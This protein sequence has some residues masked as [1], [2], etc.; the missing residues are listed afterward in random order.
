[1]LNMLPVPPDDCAAGHDEAC[2][3][4]PPGG[5]VQGKENK[6]QIAGLWLFHQYFYLCRGSELI[7]VLCQLLVDFLG[8]DMLLDSRFSFPRMLSRPLLSC[9]CP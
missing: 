8:L 4:S 9:R 6:I 3:G 1:M 2:R 5:F 7:D